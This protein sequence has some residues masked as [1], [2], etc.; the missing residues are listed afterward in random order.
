MDI[1]TK[2][3]HKAGKKVSKKKRNISKNIK[4]PLLKQEETNSRLLLNDVADSLWFEI[5]LLILAVGITYGHTLDVPFYLDD[6]LS[7]V[8]NQSI[9]N[10]HHIQS[11]WHF[12]P[13]R[14]LGYFS[15]AINRGWNGLHPA[16]YHLVN[17]FIHF[18]AGLSVLALLK[19]LLKSPVLQAQADTDV[20][21][22]PLV[23]ALIFILH[24]LQTEAVTYVVQRLASLAALFYLTSM[25]FYV[26]GRVGGEKFS[27]YKK[28]AMFFACVMSAVCAFFT[29]QNTVTLPVAIVLIELIFFQPD[30]KRLFNILVLAVIVL[31][32]SWFLLSIVSGQ[33]PFSLSAM[34]ALSRE[35]KQI[36]RLEYLA[37]QT[38]VLWLYIRYFIFPVG[39]HLDHDIRVVTD[40]VSSDP[41]IFLCCHIL[42]L[43]FAYFSVKKKPIISF[44]IFFYYL[45]H[46]V[47]S[48]F[49]PIRDVFFEHRTYLPN[50]GMC[51]VAGWLLVKKLPGWVGKKIAMVT[52]VSLLV[53]L[54]VL[55]WQRNNLWR[56]PV[57][58]WS[59]NVRL[60]PE[61][62]RAWDSLAQCLLESGR[63]NEARQA[64]DEAI[65]LESNI[66]GFINWPSVINRIILLRRQGHFD[67]AITTANK[68]LQ[69][70][71]NARVHAKI[72]ASKGNV[73]LEAKKHK[74]AEQCFRDALSV[75]P[76]YIPAE[77][78]LGIALYEEGKF[79]EAREILLKVSNNKDQ[80]Q[81]VVR[82]YLDMIER[83]HG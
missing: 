43:T 33:S 64:L 34:E 81:K 57:A 26:Y 66:P 17:I 75:Y 83:S 40:P 78:N 37:T 63:N 55:T 56:H 7:I 52:V 74:E 35:T 72:L 14:F 4:Q 82:K 18:L 49:I 59:D 6:Y 19:G 42:L 44:G 51:I 47:E 65:R 60:A 53:V 80:Y 69:K 1:A 16:G 71:P 25:V 28:I 13:L 21:W 29:K 23:S 2:K 48:G 24:P 12:A 76:G 10:W 79:Q 30:L 22:F 45:A 54:A 50:A 46:T 31:C 77:V 15:F 70:N 67:E 58:F 39:L 38:K 61:K 73:Y 68:Y 5:L 11:I 20:K 41:I 27:R 8:E 32:F 9:A 36:S 3:T 62:Y